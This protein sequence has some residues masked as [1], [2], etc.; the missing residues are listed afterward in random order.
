MFRN[1]GSLSAPFVLLVFALGCPPPEVEPPDPVDPPPTVEDVAQSREA[2]LKFIG[3][4]RYAQL[5][6]EVLEIDRSDVCKELNT[7]DCIDVIH[8]ITLGGVEPYRQ[9]VFEPL[10]VAPVTAPI[11]VD[12]VALNACQARVDQELAGDA[13]AFLVRPSVEE[14]QIA[15][16][17]LYERA[18][19]RQAERQE[20]DALLAFADRVASSDVDDAD[21]A[22]GTLFCMSVMTSLE[23]LFY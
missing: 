14:K 6:A 10:E 4:E 17:T 13:D 3:G 20:V 22:F 1:I 7:F 12:R 16:Q 23:A 8:R 21:A 2:K 9:L 11:A 19:R 5:L 15:I 18:F